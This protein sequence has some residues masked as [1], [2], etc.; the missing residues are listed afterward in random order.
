MLLNHPI[1]PLKLVEE[2][3]LSYVSGRGHDVRTVIL[4]PLLRYSGLGPIVFFEYVLLLSFYPFESGSLDRLVCLNRLKLIQQLKTVGV[5]LP[6]LLFMLLLVW[7]LLLL[8]VF[9]GDT[10]HECVCAEIQGQDV[11]VRDYALGALED[12]PFG[13]GLRIDHELL[14]LGLLD[15]GSRCSE[16]EAGDPLEFALIANVE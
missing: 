3:D 13:L 4:I 7:A 5:A 8:W 12:R 6:P 2:R 14:R 10:V 1:I 16:L 11:S 9:V 15:D